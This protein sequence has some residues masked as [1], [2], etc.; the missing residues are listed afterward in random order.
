MTLLH[1]NDFRTLKSLFI[2]FLSKLNESAF[3]VGCRE[4]YH[5]L[6]RLDI[7]QALIQEMGHTIE[8]N[9]ERTIIGGLL[10]TFC[11]ID[12]KD[13]LINLTDEDISNMKREATEKR[14]KSV[15]QWEKEHEQEC[16]AVGEK[17]RKYYLERLKMEG[18]MYE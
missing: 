17:F 7:I 6:G 10:I 9:G 11:K 1:L 14:N 5:M 15:E 18:R 13:V 16:K 12:D 8:I 2:K 3:E 4:N